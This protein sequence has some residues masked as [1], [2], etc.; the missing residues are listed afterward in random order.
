MHRDTDQKR[1]QVV[2]REKRDGS[3]HAVDDKE[4][5]CHAH[6]H[7][8]S[9]HGQENWVDLDRFIAHLN[10]PAYGVN[11]CGRTENE[12]NAK[13]HRTSDRPAQSAGES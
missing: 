8:R 7:G 2:C 3:D 6:E 13:N 12:G 11:N 9:R 1:Q 5:V 10:G 4:R